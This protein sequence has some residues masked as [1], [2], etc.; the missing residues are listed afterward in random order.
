MRYGSL[1]SITLEISYECLAF[2][3]TALADA[4]Q[5]AVV[6]ITWATRTQPLL[7]REYR[8]DQLV[9]RLIF[10]RMA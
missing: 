1:W 6:D 9:S 7:V 5:I 2:K 8:I 10:L 3:V 4:V